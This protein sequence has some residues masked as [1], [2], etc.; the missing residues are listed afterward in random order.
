[1]LQPWQDLFRSEW[2]ESETSATRLEGWNDLGLVVADDA[3]SHIV[4]V[5]FDDY[6]ER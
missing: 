2:S 5:L 1:M 4:R 6:K 3:E